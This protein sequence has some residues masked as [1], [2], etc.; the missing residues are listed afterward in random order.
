[1]AVLKAVAAG[2]ISPDQAATLIQVIA[3]QTRIM[4]AN[5]LQRRI[6][7]LEQ[8]IKPPKN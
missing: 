2:D 3:A 5:D 8:A 7:L 1:M 6:E 4:E